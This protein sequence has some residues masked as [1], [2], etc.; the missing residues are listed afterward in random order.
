MS[1]SGPSL[2]WWDIT[3]GIFL[4]SQ[5]LLLLSMACYAA[6]QPPT[7]LHPS[8][9]PQSLLRE[10][11]KFEV[12]QDACSQILVPSAHT[13]TLWQEYH[14]EGGHPSAERT[15]SLLKERF[16]WYR[17]RRDSIGKAAECPRCV[18]YKAGPKVIAPLVPIETSYPFHMVGIDFLS[19]GHPGDTHPYILVMT[20][21]FSKYALA[22]PT[23]DPTAAT[24][25][26]AVWKNLF[27]VYESL[28]YIL[29]DRGAAFT[30]DLF[31]QLCL[32]YG[33]RMKR[34]TAYHPQGNGACERFNQTLLKLLGTLTDEAHMAP[35]SCMQCQCVKKLST[36]DVC[37]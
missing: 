8:I 11:D 3:V 20:N 18:V 21:L 24:T 35:L 1:R 4:H 34:T 14:I 10:W 22:V 36:C 30:S 33:C 13:K 31:Q 15:L 16:F 27:Q 28:E 2:D 29:S 37:L 17:M 19:L 25:A 6:W 26:K 5:R 23:R 12:G 32:L 7:R 9:G